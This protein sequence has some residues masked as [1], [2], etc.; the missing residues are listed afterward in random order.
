M[1]RSVLLVGAALVS[2]ELAACATG[3]CERRERF[4]EERCS[5]SGLAY[6]PDVSCPAKI[7]H[8][9]E[10]QLQAMDAYVSCLERANRC[11]MEVVAQCARAHAG[12]VNL[13]CPVR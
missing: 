12:G 9:T 13:A 1:K 8:C 6:S 5:G 3:L 4:F 2:L 7:R 11:S 10:A